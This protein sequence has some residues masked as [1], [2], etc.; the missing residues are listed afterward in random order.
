[1]IEN[2]VLKTAYVEYYSD[3][4]I[5][6][7]AAQAI[8]RDEDTIIRW[9]KKDKAFADAVDRAHAEWIR[10]KVIAS[11]AEFA[12]ERLEKTIFGRKTLLSI[13]ANQESA[14]RDPE[15]AT[16]FANYLKDRTRQ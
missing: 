10:K 3:V 7:Y 13:E 1:M 16:L 14:P 2:D 11:K 8:C 12:L 4:P 6:K 9:R 15:L 5:Q